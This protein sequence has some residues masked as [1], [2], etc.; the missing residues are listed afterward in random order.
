MPNAWNGLLTNGNDGGRVGWYRVRFRA[1][2]ALA[3]RTWEVRFDGVRRNADVWLNGVKLGANDIPYAP[4]TLPASS[5]LAGATNTLVVRVDNVKGPSTLPEDWWNWG[6]IVR[7]VT[8]EPVGRIALA[9]L[10]T[11]PELGCNYQCGDVLVQG[12]VRNLTGLRLAPQIAV[13]LT[14]PSGQ[15]VS[16][17]HSIALIP[18]GGSVPISFHVPVSAPALWSPSTPNLYALQVTTSVDKRVEQVDT[19]RV[20]MRSVSVVG[21]VLYLNGQRL[22]LHGAA[23]HEDV[24]GHGPALSDG[25]IYTIVSELRSLGANVT[26]AHYLLDPRLLDA[27]DAAG[28]MVW[29]QAPVDHADQVLRSAAGRT[30]ALA[31]LRATLLGD[32][33]HPS[34]IVNSVGNEL[35]PTPDTTP[36]TRAY[37]QP[38]IA[39]VRR[40]DPAAR[41]GLDTYCYPGL[42][43]QQIYQSLDV[44]GI[45][46]YFGWYTG[47]PGHSIADFAGLQPFLVQS[48]SAYPGVALVVAE[49][50]AEALYDGPVAT[51]GTYEFQSDYLQ[52]TLAVVDQL[53]FMNGAIYWTLREFAEVPGWTGGAALPPDDP[54]DGV[55]HKGLLAYDGT[56]KPAF[57][58]AQQL[59]AL[60]PSFAH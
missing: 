26:R 44:L 19:R 17:V 12:V 29:E 3:A 13:K 34:V 15:V 9:D 49:F 54:P 36:A 60:T 16:T 46:S 21:G 42:P 5:L 23:I 41:V 4:F 37:L 10:G 22:W 2:R 56:P 39:L 20:G 7:A 25:D 58:V 43:A 55:H 38:A 50:G 40:L 33:S 48:H 14:S 57:A 27:L 51:K 6:G 30:K 1:P 32:R 11:M 28:I 8:L 47:P 53:P 24:Y 59:F 18:P 45:A 35:T 31:A 52:K